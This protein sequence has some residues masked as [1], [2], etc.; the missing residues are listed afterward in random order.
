M[1]ESLIA[2]TAKIHWK[3]HCSNLRQ[4]FQ[5][6]LDSD[7]FSDVAFVVGGGKRIKGHKLI[8]ATASKFLRRIFLSDEQRSA[9]SCLILT[10][11]DSD[12]L[13]LLK[14][15]LYCGVADINADKLK[16]F[17]AAAGL[18][19][20]TDI[21]MDT[22]N[23]ADDN[24]NDD[25]DD[26]DDEAMSDDEE[27]DREN[28]PINF[29]H[30]V[31]WDISRENDDDTL[32]INEDVLEEMDLKD[33]RR[34]NDPQVKKSVD[35]DIYPRKNSKTNMGPRP[36]SKTNDDQVKCDFCEFKSYIM[37]RVEDH[38]AAEHREMK[39]FKC[40]QCDYRGES[41]SKLYGHIYSKHK[42]VNER[43]KHV[44]RNGVPIKCPHC[45][46]TS[47]RTSNM[48][49]HIISRHKKEKPFECEE[50]DYKAATK[51]TLKCHIINVHTG[52]RRYECG[53][54]EFK[55]AM[56][57]NLRWHMKSVH[58]VTFEKIKDEESETFMSLEM[59]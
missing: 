35:F 56:S 5:S 19:G 58:N 9:D 1:N 28:A 21:V 57:K 4:S 55:A 36:Y 39:A 6:A 47:D 46:Y 2:M 38:I 22:C 20:V 30:S 32:V 7:S 51:Y 45:D 23:N 29:Q 12:S 50:C 24:D 18:L 8:F 41:K 54:C 44:R 15:V 11:V 31:F 26:N 17:F 49:S 25:N 33:F 48:R 14:R 40:G 10:G 13:E 16:G 37:K 53:M 42:S 34:K 43:R 59:A 3:D 52:E 27:E